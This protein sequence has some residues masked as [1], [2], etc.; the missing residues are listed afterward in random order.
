MTALRYILAVLCEIFSITPIS[1]DGYVEEDSLHDLH[2]AKFES[3]GFL[4]MATLKALCMTMKKHFT[5]ALWMRVRLSAT[6]P[7]SLNGC[8]GPW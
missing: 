7:A 1:T 4:S 5:I 3:S 2:A 8:G 6:T